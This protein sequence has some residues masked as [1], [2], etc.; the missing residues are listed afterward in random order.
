MKKINWK[1]RLKQPYFW[2]GLAGVIFTA[3]GLDA[4]TFT[5]W[6][7]VWEAF[8]E[9]WKNPYMIVSVAL[10]I[11]G[12]ISDPT[13]SGLGDSVRALEYDSPNKDNKYL[14]P[15]YIDDASEQY[16]VTDPTYNNESESIVSDD[17]DF[18][19]E[20]VSNDTEL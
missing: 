2:I 5:S 9:F 16:T 20:S 14:Q 6:S 19:S 17:S 11:I 7:A 10:A 8:I 3:T 1:V 13:T 15:K 12:V 18:N 4:T